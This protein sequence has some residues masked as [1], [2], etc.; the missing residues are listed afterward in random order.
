MVVFAS[1]TDQSGTTLTLIDTSGQCTSAL[2]TAF[3]QQ[4]EEEKNNGVRL[5]LTNIRAKNPNTLRG[6]PS[7]TEEVVLV[8]TAD[9]TACV[10]VVED[11]DSDDKDGTSSDDLERGGDQSRTHQHG[12]T[13]NEQES[14]FVAGVQDIVLGGESLKQSDFAAFR[15]ISSFRA[16]LFS[17]GSY[18]DDGIVHIT[19]WGAATLDRRNECHLR[20]GPSVVQSLCGGLDA[21]ELQEDDKLC[22]TAMNLVRAI[23]EED[24]LLRW[25]VRENLDEK[26]PVDPIATTVVL[27]SL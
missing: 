18:R 22:E 10:V 1:V 21:S 5:V 9:T 7:F 13:Q 19:S 26:S 24:M 4:K 16:V 25:I 27:H 17:G 11:D 23:L 15:S 8:P 2:Q 14:K 20:V 12:P 6:L 3:R